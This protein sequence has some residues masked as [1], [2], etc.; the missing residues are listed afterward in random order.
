MS[1]EICEVIEKLGLNM[2]SHDMWFCVD[3]QPDCHQH[4]FNPLVL[5]GDTLR[6]HTDEAEC[7]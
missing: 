3:K 4:I 6:R 5:D 2:S 7:R 1:C